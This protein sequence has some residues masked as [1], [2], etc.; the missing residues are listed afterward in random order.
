MHL[1]PWYLWTAEDD[2]EIITF[3]LRLMERFALDVIVAAPACST[4]LATMVIPATWQETLRKNN[5]TLRTRESVFIEA[6]PV[7]VID[8]ILRYSWIENLKPGWLLSALFV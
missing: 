5:G 1:Q 4:L 2:K 8:A 6:K 7:D 3:I